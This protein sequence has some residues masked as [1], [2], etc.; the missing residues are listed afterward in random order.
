MSRSK[1]LSVPETKK[2]H[3]KMVRS[4]FMRHINVS[5]Y[6]YKIGRVDY[7]SYLFSV[8]FFCSG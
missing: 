4:Q 8:L 7:N 5:V 1:V 3:T 2:G 6:T